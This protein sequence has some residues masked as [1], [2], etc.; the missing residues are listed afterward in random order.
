M[1]K[2]PLVPP[3][4]QRLQAPSRIVANGLACG[5]A[6]RLEALGQMEAVDFRALAEH[7]PIL[8]WVAAADGHIH[9]YNR[10]WYEYT[11]STPED[12]E[13]WGWQSVHDAAALPMV[14]ERWRAAIASGQP[15]EM[16]FPLRDASGRFRPFLTRAVPAR[17]PDG[18]VAAWYGVNTDITEQIHAE[19]ALRRAETALR[20]LNTGLEREVEER[21]RE[22]NEARA[23]AEAANRAKS[24]FLASMSHEIRTPL[25]GVLGYADLLRDADT[26][27]PR[28]I[29][30]LERLQTSGAAL[31]TVVNDVLDFSKIE[32]G[33][34]ELN[35]HPFA[36]AALIDN[37]ISIVRSSA[38]TKGLTLTVAIDPALPPRLVGD[39]DRLR[40]VLLNLL[41]NAIKF[42]AIGS[43]ALTVKAKPSSSAPDRWTLSFSITDTGIGI[44]KEKAHRL[45]ERF[46]QIDG[47]IAREHGGTGLGLA[48]SRSL[49]ELMDGRITLESE[50]GRGSTFR[51]LISLPVAPP[52]ETQSSTSIAPVASGTAGL[53]ILVAEDVEVNQEIIRAVLER[54][55]HAVDIV[56]DGA[57]AVRA[58]QSAAYDLVLMDVQM[59]G[60]DGIAATG[61]I[62]ALPHPAAKLPI[63]AMTANVLPQQVAQFRAAGMND[64]VGKPFKRDELYATIARWSGGSSPREDAPGRS[65]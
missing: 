13:G 1:K 38:E 57:A 28:Q 42:T 31:L 33:R 8:C 11:G 48:I 16:T 10:R 6:I 65:L 25:H 5:T 35:T 62:R 9:W 3:M 44:P 21:N 39:Q 64:H 40:Q 29:Q 30:Q 54:A 52:V 63:I 58:V 14:L 23:Q 15:F 27:T 60:M 24:D 46:S 22:A 19:Q 55:H 36:P 59:P 47:T 26:L 7:M 50:E 61:H 32:A 51:V 41:S 18:A 43:V 56:A 45:F 53:R 49:V 37:A 17:G 2:V 4:P 20:D 12:M 34:F